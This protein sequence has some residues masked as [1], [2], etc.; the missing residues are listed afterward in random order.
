MNC[1]RFPNYDL[2]L[3][4]GYIRFNSSEENSQY[5]DTSQKSK[6]IILSNYLRHK[7]PFRWHYS[8]AIWT[9]QALKKIGCLD[10]NLFRLIDAD[11]YTRML[12][13]DLNYLEIISEKPDFY[14][15]ATENPEIAKSKQ[16]LFVNNS[17]I[18][19][20]KILDLT[21]SKMQNKRRFVRLNFKKF[22]LHL[23]LVSLLSLPNSKY[24]I[25]RITEFSLSEDLVSRK[26]FN[27]IKYLFIYKN[28]KLN[29]AT[30]ILLHK[31]YI[32]N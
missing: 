15:R 29:N 31:L 13:H 12:L 10:D 17:L 14:Y 24:Y 21:T 5:M 6:V 3:F 4:P 11:L 23:F 16:I 32:H 19:I 28:K 9:K 7:L 1:I 20:K 27:I 30:W 26:I 8:N 2:W 25:K 18:Y 22:I